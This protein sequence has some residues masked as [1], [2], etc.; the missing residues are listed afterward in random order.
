VNNIAVD[1]TGESIPPALPPSDGGL[2]T[3][4]AARFTQ[5][6][7]TQLDTDP[8]V[9][10]LTQGTLFQATETNDVGARSFLT[11][12]IMSNAQGDVLIA[13]TTTAA[14]ERL[15]AAVAQ[16]IENNSAVGEP[17]LYTNSVSDYNAT[18]DWEFNPLARWGDHTRVSPDPADP[19]AFWTVQQ[20]CSDTN[21]WGLE[22][23]RVIANK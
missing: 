5:I 14:D 12:S 17:V 18:E 8:E 9:A 20:W 13:A 7:I 6:D 21:T 2:M 16:L 10:V 4:D 15:N 1:N 11:P 23:G 3:R 19:A 22:V